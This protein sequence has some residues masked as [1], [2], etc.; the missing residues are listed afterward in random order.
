MGTAIT[1][2][3]TQLRSLDLRTGDSMQ[4]DLLGLGLAQ[5]MALP[6]VMVAKPSPAVRSQANETCVQRKTWNVLFA[7]AFDELRNPHVLQHKIPLQDLM[8]FIGFGRSKNTGYLKQ[9]LL[10]LMRTPVTWGVVDE[11]GNEIWEASAALAA[12]RFRD[13]ICYYE[14]SSVMREKLCQSQRFALF[15][16]AEQRELSTLAA[17]ALHENCAGYRKMQQSPALPLTTW[18]R[19][20]G[21]DAKTYDDFRRFNEKILNPAIK[22]VNNFTSYEIEPDY[23]RLDKRVVGIRF[24]IQYR[25]RTSDSTTDEEEQGG[26]GEDIEALP[27]LVRQ[28]MNDILL[29]RGQAEAVVA[30]N[31]DAR[32]LQVMQY[33]TKRYMAGKVTGALPAYFL[34]T[35]QKYEEVPAE[36]ALDV[37]RREAEQAKKSIEDRAARLRQYRDDFAIVWRSRAQAT[38]DAL[39]DDQ[40]AEVLRQFEADLIANDNQAAL[41]HWKGPERDTSMMVASLLRHFVAEQFL[42]D[43]DSAFGEWVEAQEEALLQAA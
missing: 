18:R 39:P 2:A 34:G 15:D 23:I 19:L 6:R 17:V 13:G 29:T 20:L 21:A 9:Q 42:P 37:Q 40:R 5:D 35:L 12:A 26:E 22:Q 31:S 7:N 32:V 36:S 41:K 10:D 4:G 33:V 1:R 30:A 16:L 11:R 25:G 43:K 24:L 38:L 8:T 27:L 14:Y 3:A 28:L